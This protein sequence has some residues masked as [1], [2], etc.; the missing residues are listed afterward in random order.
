MVDVVRLATAPIR[1]EVPNRRESRLPLL[2]DPGNN[3]R[4]DGAHDE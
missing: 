1:L 2:L 4:H 3:K